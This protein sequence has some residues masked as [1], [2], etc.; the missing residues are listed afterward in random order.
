[1]GKAAMCIK[2]LEILN[3]GR[4]YKISELAYLLETNPRNINEYKKELEE[5]GYYVTSIPGRYGGL[6]L[7]QHNLIP[8]LSFIE[9]EKEALMESYTYLLSKNL[10]VNKEHYER[11]MAK[12]MSSFDNTK[13]DVDLITVLEKEA[14]I[15]ES[16]KI[17]ATYNLLK[18]C[19]AKSLKVEIQYINNKGNSVKKTLRPYDLYVYNEN[20]FLIAECEETDSFSDYKLS[21]IEAIKN[22][23]KTFS[24]D[25]YYKKS[26]YLDEAGYKRNDEWYD[27]KFEVSG[28][29]L[30]KIK[31]RVIGKNQTIEMI[32]KNKAIVSISMQY[33][34][35]IINFIMGLGS[36]CKVIEP[37][38]LVDQVLKITKEMQDIYLKQETE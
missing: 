19:I 21:K 22:L 34:F 4:V 17:K 23:N 37:K 32:D 24:R 26:D 10:F 28:Y 15:L 20:W 11:A 35:N 5:C 6:K 7:E 30:S 25:P 33:R 12:V 13:D 8:P 14:S 18:I 27:I 16:D 31:D 3:T 2:M 38:W 9:E 36:F 1:M 29:Y